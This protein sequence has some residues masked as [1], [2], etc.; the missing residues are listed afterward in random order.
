MWLTNAPNLPQ[1]F[2]GLGYAFRAIRSQPR[3]GYGRDDEGLRGRTRA[4]LLHQA[5]SSV[6]IPQPQAE[7]E[8]LRHDAAASTHD[9]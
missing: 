1:E 3:H 4:A 8:V 7:D 9:P 6:H 5:P 2:D